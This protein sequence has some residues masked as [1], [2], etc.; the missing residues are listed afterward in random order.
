MCFCACLWLHTAC[1]STHQQ[2]PT[3]SVPTADCS[4]LLSVWSA[5]IP[6]RPPRSPAPGPLYFKKVF[7]LF[8]KRPFQKVSQQNSNGPFCAKELKIRFQP[9]PY[10]RSATRAIKTTHGL[11]VLVEWNHFWHLNILMKFVQFSGCV[12]DEEIK[13]FLAVLINRC[14][15]P[16]WVVSCSEINDTTFYLIHRLRAGLQWFSFL[17][18]D[19]WASWLYMKSKTKTGTFLELENQGHTKTHCRVN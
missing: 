6:L 3:D 19:T 1:H 12:L 15:Q 9:C 14:R 11:N 7:A 17:L 2:T 4:G 13:C 5:K 8:T 10:R 18:G 16:L